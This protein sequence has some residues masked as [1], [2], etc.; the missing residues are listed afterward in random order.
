MTKTHAYKNQNYHIIRILKILKMTE[1]PDLGKVLT[2]PQFGG[3]PQWAVVGKF[4][5]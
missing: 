3:L 5:L 2:L 4:N 1:L